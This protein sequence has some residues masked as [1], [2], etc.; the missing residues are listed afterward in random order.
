MRKR[1]KYVVG[2]DDD[3]QNIYGLDV[4][5]S[6]TYMDAMG[7]KEATRIQKEMKEM[8][9]CNNDYKHPKIIIYELVPIRIEDK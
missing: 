3:G 6:S 7:I 1:K 5:D 2:F 8:I 4:N 9:E